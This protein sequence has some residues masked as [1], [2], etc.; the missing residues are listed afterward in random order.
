MRVFHILRLSYRFRENETTLRSPPSVLRSIFSPMRRL[1]APARK[2]TFENCDEKIQQKK[3]V[4]TDNRISRLFFRKGNQQNRASRGKTATFP[5]LA[6]AARF[7]LT[8]GAAIIQVFS[9]FSVRFLA[10]LR[11][12]LCRRNIRASGSSSQRK[13]GENGRTL[14]PPQ[15]GLLISM[16]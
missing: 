9:A 15:A 6:L 7:S 16:Y 14:P 5:W 13:E 8:A 11:C 3:R 4:N 12:Y 2:K 1:Y 10:T